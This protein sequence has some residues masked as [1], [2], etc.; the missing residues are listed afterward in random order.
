MGRGACDGTAT[1]GTM[2][3]RRTRVVREGTDMADAM[4]IKPG[5]KVKLKEHDPAATPGVKD[6]GAALEE[7]DRLRTE[8]CQ[9]QERLYAEHRRALLVV[10]QAMDT[11]GKDGTVKS[12]M[13]GVNPAGVEITSFKAPS[14]EERAHDFLWRVHQ[15]VPRKG[16]I[17]IFNRS[18]Y[19]DVLIARVHGLAAPKEIEHRYGVINRFEENLTETGTVV[20]KFFL[21][22]SKDEQKRRL[23]ERLADPT[24]VWKFDP[25]DLRE[26]EKWDDYQRAY[27]VALTRCSTKHAPWSIVP[28]DRKWFRNVVVARGVVAALRE[29]DPQPPPA[30]FDPAAIA[31][32]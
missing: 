27:E 31:V 13:S 8:M 4:V 18:H 16:N 17:G 28:A 19:E 5:S 14:E 10:V 20:L 3:A 2:T 22:I 15:R 1:A 21:H 6:K 9:L 23:E 7:L 12:V 24:K 29:M 25:S 11:G 26:R 32:T 30:T